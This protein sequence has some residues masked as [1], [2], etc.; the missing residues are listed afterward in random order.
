MDRKE[1]DERYKWN[2]DCIYSNIDDFNRD[3]EI[4][5]KEIASFSDFQD[6]M[7]RG[8]KEFYETICEYY[9]ISRKLEKLAVYTSLLFDT[10]TSDNK[11]QALKGKVD[12]LY[13]EF[14]KVSY[15]VTPTILKHDYSDIEKFYKEDSRLLDYEI[16]L[17]N[18]F[19]YKD[20]NLSDI[21][22]KLLSSLGKMLNRNYET[23]ELLKDSDLSFGVIQDSDGNEVELTDSNYSVYIESKDRRVRKDA[24]DTL[25]KT[26]HQYINTFASCM[27]GFFKNTL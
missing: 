4:V 6:K 8:A 20:H 2:L 21:E 14:S 18:Q 12:N 9:Q 16:I 10:D 23:Y 22:E 25:Y 3:Y 11:N 26:Y 17:K 1:I 7:D 24:F 19:R 5:K 13:D 27:S 15:F